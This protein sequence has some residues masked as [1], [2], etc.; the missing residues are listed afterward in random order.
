M[1]NKFNSVLALLL[2]PF[3]LLNFNVFS[4]DYVAPKVVTV[5]VGSCSQIDLTGLSAAQCLKAYEDH[6]NAIFFDETHYD[7]ESTSKL[8]YDTESVKQ[9]TIAANAK[10]PSES[11]PKGYKYTSYSHQNR[12]WE[13]LGEDE[14]F[15]CPPDLPAHK[16]YV[17][18]K[19]LNSDGDIDACFKSKLETCPDGNYAFKVGGACVPVQ[20]ESAGSGGSIWAKGDIYNNNAGT[21]CDGSC[22]HTV[23]AGQNPTGA[24]GNVAI[25]AVSTGESCG[26]GT[27]TAMHD[28]DGSDC[29][30]FDVGTGT[31]FLS[32]SN[33]SETPEEA[34]PLD[35]GEQEFVLLEMQELVPV[36]ETCLPDDPSCEIRNL[37][38]TTQTENNEQKQLAVELHNK[39]VKAQETSTQ[40]LVNT[41][42]N[43]SNQQTQGL[44]IINDAIKDLNQDGFGSGGGGGDG[45]EGLCD[46]DGNCT[47]TVETKTEPAEGLEGFWVSDYEDG[48]EGIFEDQLVSLQSSEFYLF[49]DN[50]NPSISGG[51]APDMSMCFNLGFINFGC[52]SFNIDPRVYPA[53]RIFILISAAFLCRRI[54]FGG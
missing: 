53:I 25:Y 48:L 9:Y 14:I 11:D 34:A 3:F 6:Y 8:L 32:C 45:E 19:D 44:E 18:G 31:N 54:L 26:Q 5:F 13:K 16:D 35:L 42:V 1:M 24:T 37:K 51:S 33:E 4:Q 17:F 47:T 21:Y 39:T 12:F 46:I 10:Y 2:M 30:S 7:I 40:T 22:A 20:C 38:E 52:H 23:G 27:D 49:L 41:L 15:S 29:E 36:Q 28:G 50:F 43:N